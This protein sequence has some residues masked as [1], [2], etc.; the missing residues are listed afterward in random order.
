[1]LPRLTN[2][3]T[4]HYAINTLIECEGAKSLLPPIEAGL[5]LSHALSP[6]LLKVGLVPPRRAQSPT[7]GP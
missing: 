4:A 5:Q 3:F 7:A 1:M 6:I 2:S